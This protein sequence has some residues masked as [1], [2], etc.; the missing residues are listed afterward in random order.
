M[1]FS[2]TRLYVSCQASICS[3]LNNPELLLCVAKDVVSAGAFGIRAEGISNL[4]L[5]HENLKVPIISLVKSKYQD[6]S[7]CI[8]RKISQINKLVE[9]GCKTIAVDGTN[10]IIDSM[11]GSMFITF[12][13]NNFPEVSIIADVSTLEEAVSSLYAGAN[14]VATTLRGYTPW[15]S[16]NS[17]DNFDFNFLD[18]ICSE[19]SPNKIVAEGRISSPSIFGDLCAYNLNSIVV[20][21]AISDPKYLTKNFLGYD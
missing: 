11:T 20:G 4:K 13:K 15:T 6:G 17:Y 2:K 10:R 3:H 21:K 12:I 18:K 19:I 14:Y 1:S 16:H 9:V 8:T 5:M 7:V